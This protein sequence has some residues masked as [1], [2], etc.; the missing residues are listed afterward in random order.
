[1]TEGPQGS[2]VKTFAVRLPDAL[3]EQL[4]LI[5]RLENRSLNA[6]VRQAIEEL[7]QRKR[8]EGD[9]A[10]RARAALDEIEQEAATRRAAIESLFGP[11]EQP[12]SGQQ[13]GKDAGERP[14]SRKQPP[15]RP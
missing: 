1:M 15:A 13:S 8:A 7:I 10:Q 3:H 2:G 12:P 6:V 14:Q 4:T 5:T 9:F 11:G